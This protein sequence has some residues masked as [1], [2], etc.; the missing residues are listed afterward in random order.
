MGNAPKQLPS[1]NCIEILIK[2]KS[3]SW[4]HIAE[5]RRRMWKVQSRNHRNTSVNGENAEE[6]NASWG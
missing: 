3:K 4:E 2:S 1:Y 5:G 6:N